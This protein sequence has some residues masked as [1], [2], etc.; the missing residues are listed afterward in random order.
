[1][2]GYR[3]FTVRLHL[4]MLMV[5]ILSEEMFILISEEMLTEQ[6]LQKTNLDDLLLILLK[7]ADVANRYNYQKGDYRNYGME[8]LQSSIPSRRLD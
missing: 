5:S 4:K 8:I 6:L 1:M 2:N 3:M 7:H